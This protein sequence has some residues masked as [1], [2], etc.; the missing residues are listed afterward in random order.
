MTSAPRLAE[1]RNCIQRKQRSGQL[2]EAQLRAGSQSV[3]GGH[4]VL[5]RPRVGGFL[6]CFNLC[7]LHRSRL[8]GENRSHSMSEIIAADNRSS[9]QRLFIFCELVH[10]V[11]VCSLSANCSLTHTHTPK[12]PSPSL[13]VTMDTKAQDLK[14]SLPLMC[15]PHSLESAN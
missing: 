7:A 10:C 13:P 9:E 3:R 4:R 11:C 8:V 5:Y 14:L 15:T 1:Q 2:Q 6:Y 12:T